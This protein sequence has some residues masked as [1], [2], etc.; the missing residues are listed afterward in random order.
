VILQPRAQLLGAHSVDACGTGVLLDASERL[1]EVLAGE[2]LLPQARLGGVSGGVV[3]R[4]ADALLWR[5]VFGLHPLTFPTRPPEGLAAVN[6]TATSTNVFSLGFAF[7]P[8][9]RT[10]IARYYDLC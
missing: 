6:A 2:H 1:G 8:S 4:R 5:R 7:G 9:R 10:S 3:R